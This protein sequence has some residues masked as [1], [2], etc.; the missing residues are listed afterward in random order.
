MPEPITF[1]KPPEGYY[2]RN[3]YYLGH[4]HIQLVQKR[5]YWR[6]NVIAEFSTE[7]VIDF[8]DQYEEKF[9]HAVALAEAGVDNR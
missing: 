7:L 4:Y 9:R 1:P 6:D 5:R 8:P 2:W 3:K